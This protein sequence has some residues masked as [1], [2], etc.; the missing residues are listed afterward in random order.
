MQ[1][2]TM[3]TPQSQKIGKTER[4]HRS[5]LISLIFLIV[6]LIGVAIYFIFRA[7]NPRPKPEWWMYDFC[8][9]L[10]TWNIRS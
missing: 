4:R 3:E 9:R 7:S 8:F 10:P 1:N 6:L 5:L 2:L